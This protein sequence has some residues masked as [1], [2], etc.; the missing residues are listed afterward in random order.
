MVDV[1]ADE[2]VDV[3]VVVGGVDGVVVDVVVVVVVDAVVVVVDVVVCIASRYFN[4]KPRLLTEPSDLNSILNV[5][6]GD[7]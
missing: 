7:I 5:L 2:G 6:S 4:I 1:E 3:E